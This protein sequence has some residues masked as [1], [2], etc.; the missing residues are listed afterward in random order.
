MQRRQTTRIDQ[1]G[2]GNVKIGFE[3]LRMI[4]LSSWNGS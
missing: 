3:K 1:S 2:L 4:Q